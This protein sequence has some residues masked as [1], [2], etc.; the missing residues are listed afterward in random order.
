MTG[1]TSTIGVPSSASRSVTRTRFSSIATI[2]DFVQP[3][4]V[5]ALGGASAEHPSLGIGEV[6]AR[7]N[8]QD[9]AAR[10]IQPREDDHSIAGLD[11]PQPL[12]HSRLEHQPGLGRALSA[13]L[14]RCG[15]IG[16]RRFDHS[17]RI[18]LGS[19]W[20]S[21]AHADVRISL[22]VPAEV[23]LR[24]AD[25]VACERE[26]LGVAKPAARRS[27]CSRRSRRP[28]RRPRRAA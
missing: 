24:L 14:G 19:A 21:H 22:E 26:D 7:M 1:F 23:D 17:D 28:R 2:F 12:E 18:Q 27:S 3:D 25:L 20:V 4:W 13:L 5:R 15:R 8:A 16:Q 11:L 6:V 9:V 10:T